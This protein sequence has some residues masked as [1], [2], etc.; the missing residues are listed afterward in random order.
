[1]TGIDF[2]VDV[3]QQTSIA[4]LIVPGTGHERDRMAEYELRES[5]G[6]LCCAV[7]SSTLRR[8]DTD[9]PHSFA[10]ADLYRVPVDDDGDGDCRR[11]GGWRG[12]SL[13]G[14]DLRA[15]RRFER[16]LTGRDR[17]CCGGRLGGG[18]IRARRRITLPTVPLWCRRGPRWLRRR[19]CRARPCSRPSARDTTQARLRR[20]TSGA[21]SAAALTEAS[22]PPT[23]DSMHS[24]PY[25]HVLPRCDPPDDLE[26]QTRV[27]PRVSSIEHDPARRCA[28]DPLTQS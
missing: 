20:P 10:R 25:E 13:G 16:R 28:H 8:V 27:K 18:D 23:H 2:G 1:M 6:C 7:A 4:V 12:G 3:A 26:R 21:T 15:R 14:G 11:D 19:Q 9:E 22:G 5:C 24:L 17:G